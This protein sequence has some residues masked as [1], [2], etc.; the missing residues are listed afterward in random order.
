MR[1]VIK[2]VRTVDCLIF[3]QKFQTFYKK[4]AIFLKLLFFNFQKKCFER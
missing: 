3:F 4:S 2:N 1:I